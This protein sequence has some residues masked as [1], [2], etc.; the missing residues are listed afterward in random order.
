M[1]RLSSAGARGFAP[2]LVQYIICC[3]QHEQKNLRS[4]GR[5]S[6]MTQFFLTLAHMIA[7]TDK[8]FA[9]HSLLCRTCTAGYSF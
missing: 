4:I 8:S 7:S 2:V 1:G 9:D 3:M 5:G 6:K